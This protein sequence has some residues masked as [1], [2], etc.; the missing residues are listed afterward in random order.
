MHIISFLRK[1]VFLII[2]T[3]SLF[4]IAPFLFIAIPVLMSNVA[5]FNAHQSVGIVF[6]GVLL[7]ISYGL[8]IY[9]FVSLVKRLFKSEKTQQA[10]PGKGKKR[11]V[12]MAKMAK[13]KKISLKWI[14]LALILPFLYLIIVFPFLQRAEGLSFAEKAD[15][16]EMNLLRTVFIYGFLAVITALASFWKKFLKP[17]AIS[18]LICWIL[19]SSIV[20]AVIFSEKQYY[21]PATI[22]NQTPAPS[23][24]K[25]PVPKS[26]QISPK[27][28]V[29]QP[30]QK[31]TFT[32]PELWGAVNKRRVENGVGSLGRSDE[33]CSIASFRL[34]QLWER[35]SLDNHAGFNE[36][37]QN[38]S[39]PYYWLFRKYNIWEY[40]IY[41]PSGTAED[42]VNWWEDTL[43]HKTLLDG[44]QFTIGC[45]YAHGGFGVAIAAF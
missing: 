43:G 20:A 44:G 3:A 15:V 23:P 8:I 24:L 42:A 25:S 1:F 17:V 14:L 12:K 40:I 6:A 4:I 2:F 11:L 39:S 34:N 38:E 16:G 30:Y 32:G 18:V 36:L 19:G 35:G 5:F 33:I 37:W 13:K 7:A 27:P 31:A 45:T 29:Q 21:P 10:L 28:R 26:I 22:S 41:V 9:I